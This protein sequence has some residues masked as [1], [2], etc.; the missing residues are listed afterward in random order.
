[1]VGFFCACM[2]FIRSLT[3]EI[4]MYNIQHN[5]QCIQESTAGSAGCPPKRQPRFVKIPQVWI[6][7]AQDTTEYNNTIKQASV[8]WPLSLRCM[9]ITM[10]NMHLHKSPCQQMGD[11]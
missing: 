3:I 11:P 1:M 6:P 10:M 7:Y 2:T 4:A 8:I 9:M 5:N